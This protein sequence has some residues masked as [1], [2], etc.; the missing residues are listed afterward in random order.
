M[1]HPKHCLRFT[2]PFLFELFRT[3]DLI[4]R[5]RLVFLQQFPPMGVYET[6]FQFSDVTGKYMGDSGTHPWV[7]GFPLTTQLSGGPSLPQSIQFGSADLKYPPAAGHLAL[8][9]SIA[10][11][12]N[13]FYRTDITPDHV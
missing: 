11:Y 7:Q 1:P 4:W 2:L 8:R 9:Q 6:L 3:Q 5:I 10:N 13:H 12:Y